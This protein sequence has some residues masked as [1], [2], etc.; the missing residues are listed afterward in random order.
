MSNYVLVFDEVILGQLK[1]LGKDKPTR[2][3]LSKMLD[4]IE[5]NGPMAGKLLDSRLHL[6]EVKAMHPPIRLYYKINELA[7][8]AYVFEFEMKTSPE[9]Q[10]RTIAK[11]RE[12]SKP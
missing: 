3:L 7:K 8:E 12:K 11:I 5:E 9:K 10:N 6:F 1:K 4:K 2:E